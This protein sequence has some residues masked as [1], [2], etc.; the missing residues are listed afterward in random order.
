M[1]KPVTFTR[2]S[3]LKAAF[4]IFA[5]DGL[6]A[7]SARGIAS[8]I[9]A[10]TAP[11]YSCFS[12]IDEIRIELLQISLRRLLEYT[13]K[14]YTPDLFLNIGVGL[15][16]YVKDYPRVYRAMFLDEDGNRE[17]FE[18][19]R[20]KNL[21]QMRKE[22]TI[23]AFSESQL[24]DILR[25]LT[26]YTH[27]LAALICANM[28]EDKSTGNLISLLEDAG[29]AM[30]GF[31]AFRAGKMDILDEYRRSQPGCPQEKEKK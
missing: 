19:F 27:G 5:E 9:G 13:E 3:I 10:S 6:R 12:S 20:L 28:L 17:I 21:M 1:P 31:A 8:R 11:V 25:K 4:E 24:E 30:I 2:E 7:I 15:L 18:Q 29:S 22:P 26:V 16:E 14:Q 23:S